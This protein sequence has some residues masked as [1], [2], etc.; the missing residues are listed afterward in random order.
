MSLPPAS[1]TRRRGLLI[2]LATL[3]AVPAAYVGHRVWN[4]Y[5]RPDP[6][7][8]YDRHADAQADIGR[9]VEQARRDHRL[10]LVI[11]GANWCPDCRRLDA[12]LL[13]PALGDPVRARHV[14]VKVDVGRFDRNGRLVN[15]L[16]NP[17][18]QGI[19]ALALLDG[20]GRPL[21]RVTGPQLATLRQSGDPATLVTAL[22][23]LAR[24]GALH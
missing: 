1:S 3:L 18:D 20:S 17:V 7:G 10:V 5:L 23:R 4:R 21:G 22:D 13:Q 24:T 12:D 19:P 9:A 8:P 15:Q 6:P 2:A 11:F 14:I 16:G